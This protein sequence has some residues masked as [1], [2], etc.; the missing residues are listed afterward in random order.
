M[1]IRIGALVGVMVFT[2]GISF[3]DEAQAAWRVC[4]RTAEE[5]QVA[6]AYDQGGGSFVSE[7][8]WSIPACGGCKVV[9][10]AAFPVTGVFLHAEGTGLSWGRDNL[11]CV[12]PQS[13][14][15]VVGGGNCEHRGLKTESFMTVNVPGNGMHTTNLTGRASSGKVCID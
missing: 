8:W 15:R 4:N 11:F 3:S 2:L 12:N 1:R 10:G 5:V 9:H 6:I 7:G 14:F 13:R